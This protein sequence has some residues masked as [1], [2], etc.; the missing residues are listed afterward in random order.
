MN[1]LKLKYDSFIK[2][3]FY[4]CNEKARGCQLIFFTQIAFY[5]NFPFHVFLIAIKRVN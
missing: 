5:L 3:S 4:E 1:A 2:F